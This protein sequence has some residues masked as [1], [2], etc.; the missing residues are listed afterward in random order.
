MKSRA[1]FLSAIL[2]LS[3]AAI[4]SAQEAKSLS[5]RPITLDEAVQLALK[6]NHIVRI[7]AYKVEE[8]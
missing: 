8:K 6:H 7:A 4:L 1:V 5:P 3:C 2:S